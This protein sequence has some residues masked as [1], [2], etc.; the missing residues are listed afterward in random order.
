MPFTPVHLGPG[1]LFKGIGGEKFSFMV[2]AGSQVL[3]D[4]EPGYRMIAQDSIIHGPTHT[5]A[6]AAAIGFLATLSGKPISEYVLR[7]CRY[8]RHWCVD[9]LHQK[10]GRLASTIFKSC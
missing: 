4:L 6:G 7:C 10:Q 3:M 2:F 9:D 8:G 1:A 5:I